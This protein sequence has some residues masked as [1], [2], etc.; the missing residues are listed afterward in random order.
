MLLLDAAGLL[1]AIALGAMVFYFGGVNGVGYLALIFVFLISSVIVTKYGSTKKREMALYE[2]NRGWENVVANGIIPALCIVAAPGVGL[3]GA[4][5]GSL[6][7]VTSDKFSSEVGVLGAA[8]RRLFDFK[9]AKR[10]QSGAMSLL[11]TFAAFDG[12]LMIGVAAY[13]LFGK[14]DAWG[15][16]AI[17]LIG[18]FG[19]LVDSAVGVL[20][21]QGFGNKMTTNLICAITGAVLGYLFL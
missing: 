18:F 3:L 17:T 15:V 21:N 7:A 10:G 19:S 9:P 6:A 1:V 20:E 5:V 13:L 14:Y 4:Y 2:Y 11:G 16:L 12:A 8:P